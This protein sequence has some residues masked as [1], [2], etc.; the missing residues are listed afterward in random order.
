MSTVTDEL[1]DAL[2]DQC[3]RDRDDARLPLTPKFALS[4]RVFPDECVTVNDYDC[5]GKVEPGVRGYNDH[6][7]NGARPKGFDGR[8]R[9]WDTRDGVLWWQPP[10]DLRSP[11]KGGFAT[12]EE[13]RDALDKLY[14]LVRKLCERGFYGV[15]VE[16]HETLTDSR[17]KTHEVVVGSQGLWGIDSLKNGYLRETVKELTEELLSEFSQ[18]DA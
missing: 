12:T 11:K 10:D 2:V 15:V 6:G 1:V 4:A 5:Y 13:W 18:Q 17:G 16:L 3:E 14:S 9:K 8:A 7:R